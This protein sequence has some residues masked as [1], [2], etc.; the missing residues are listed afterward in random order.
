MPTFRKCVIYMCLWVLQVAALS[1]IMC[2]SQSVLYAHQQICTAERHE[3]VPGA[4][5]D[6]YYLAAHSLK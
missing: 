2:F 6:K 4:N 1:H 5:D 3:Y